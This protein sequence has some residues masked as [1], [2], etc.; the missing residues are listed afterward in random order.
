M[1]VACLLRAIFRSYSN[2][3]IPNEQTPP[4]NI[5]ELAS[6]TGGDFGRNTTPDQNNSQNSSKSTPATHQ[7]NSAATPAQRALVAT[8]SSR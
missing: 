5:N 1:L 7:R 4:R 8:R 6:L 3:S 2:R